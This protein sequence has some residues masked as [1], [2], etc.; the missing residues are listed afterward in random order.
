MYCALAAV[1]LHQCS[2]VVR[3]GGQSS[4]AVRSTH[5]IKSCA[6]PNQPSFRPTQHRWK[7]RRTPVSETRPRDVA[8]TPCPP[9]RKQHLEL[10]RCGGLCSSMRPS[11]RP[12]RM[13]QRQLLVEERRRLVL[14]LRSERIPT[15]ADRQ[16]TCKCSSPRMAL[17]LAA[18]LGPLW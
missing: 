1:N 10:A 3:P 11:Q 13:Q 16:G 6:R 4:A 14:R 17:Q 18:G 9:P 5:L 8:A 15:L 12:R 7:C 2:A